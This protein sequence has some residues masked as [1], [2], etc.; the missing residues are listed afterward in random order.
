MV[1][2]NGQY[3]KLTTSDQ[4]GLIIV[5]M[6][7]KGIYLVKKNILKPCSDICDKLIPKVKYITLHPV[8]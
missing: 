1:T 8:G 6:L 3:H 4:Y 5:W 2:W 7:Y